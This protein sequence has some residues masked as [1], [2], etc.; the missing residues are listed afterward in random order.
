MQNGRWWQRKSRPAKTLIVLA[1]LLPVQMITLLGTPALSAWLDGLLHIP[2]GEEWGTFGA[3]LWELFFCGLTVLA[4][5]AS[6]V[7]WLVKRNK[8]TGAKAGVE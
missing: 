1:A 6:T 5:V 8:S 4:T 3:I 7:W 2:R